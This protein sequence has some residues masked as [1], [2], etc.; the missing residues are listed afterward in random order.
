MLYFCTYMHDEN[1]FLHEDGVELVK[2]GHTE[3]T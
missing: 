2:F 3:L 1:T